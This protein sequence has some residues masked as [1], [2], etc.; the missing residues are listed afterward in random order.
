MGAAAARGG[1]DARAP[2]RRAAHRRRRDS[3]LA[4]GADDLFHAAEN[5]LWTLTAALALAFLASR[6]QLV[7]DRGKRVIAAAIACGAA[8]IAFMV[9][10]DVPMYLARWQP[11]QEYLSPGEGMRELLQRCV[12]A[13]DWASW[14]EDALWLALY[15][16][17]AVWISIALPQVPRLK[18]NG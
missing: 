13:R 6:W 2:G 9:T 1:S 3:F 14:R 15:F 7:G 4:R 8:C 16:T 10:V 5:S 12:V 11:G 17:V 18:G